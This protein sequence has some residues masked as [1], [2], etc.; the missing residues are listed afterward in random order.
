MSNSTA[1]P[2]AEDIQAY[3][4]LLETFPTKTLLDMLMHS[5]LDN[6]YGKSDRQIRLIRVEILTRTSR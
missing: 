3:Q 1:A 2:S 4:D 6:D 5:A